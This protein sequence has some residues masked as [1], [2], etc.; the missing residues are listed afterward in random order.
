MGSETE[1]VMR[2]VIA[3][4][5]DIGVSLAGKLAD[6]KHTELVLIDADED[7]CKQ[8]SGRFDALVI[9]G[10]AT[11]P[12]ILQKAE[13]S[14]ADVLVATTNTDPINTV[15]A[16]L[17]HRIGVEKIIVKLNGVG[18][19]SACQ[20]IGVTRVIAP[21][22]SAAAEIL[23]TVYGFDRV[24][25]SILAHG[26]MRLVDLEAG[27]TV[28]RQLS[29]IEFPDGSH[30]V[31]VLRKDEVLLPKANFKLE[32]GD[33]LYVMVEGDKVLE[34]LRSELNPEQST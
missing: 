18:L 19:R 33:E 4:M 17:G 24:N 25:F 34:Q 12:D 5:G 16:M 26:G 31:A 2:V 8:L 23:S 13:L 29:E 20:A 7:L 1:L 10:D 15:I 32:E 30:L 3:G 6:R 21:K 22:I 27:K 14:E 9:N 28:G 11:D